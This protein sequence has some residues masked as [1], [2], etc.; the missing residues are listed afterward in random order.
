MLHCHP[1]PFTEYTIARLRK[2][3]VVDF[4]VP[5]R[6][7]AYYPDV[8]VDFSGEKRNGIIYILLDTYIQCTDEDILVLYE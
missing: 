2:A 3:L 4:Y 1:L 6:Y 7:N 5:R 8:L